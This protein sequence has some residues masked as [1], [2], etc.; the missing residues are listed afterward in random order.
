[1]RLLGF[2]PCSCTYKWNLRR[3]H[4]NVFIKEALDNDLQLDKLR[5]FYEF[6]DTEISVKMENRAAPNDLDLDIR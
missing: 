1:M 5:A 3:C 4:L 6:L 2:N